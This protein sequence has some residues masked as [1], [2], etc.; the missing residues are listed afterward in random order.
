[1]TAST[2]SSTAGADRKLA[3]I[4]KSRNSSAAPACGILRRTCSRDADCSPNPCPSTLELLRIG[5]LEAK[6]RLLEVADHEDGP[7]ATL[8]RSGAGEEFGGERLN[9]LPL[10]AVRVLDSSTRI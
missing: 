9:D 3:S 5:A 1:M 2:T 10:L 8:D 6:D 4:D 7:A